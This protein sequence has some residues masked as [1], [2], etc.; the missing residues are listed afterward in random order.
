MQGRALSNHETVTLDRARGRHSWGPPTE[1]F[2]AGQF[3]NMHQSSAING[4]R[5]LLLGSHL[6]EVARCTRMLRLPRP[7]LQALPPGGST[8]KRSGKATSPEGLPQTLTWGHATALA[9]RGPSAFPSQHCRTGQQNPV[10]KG[11]SAL[12][13]H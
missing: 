11:G 4:S 10:Q 3:G 8:S 5:I 9:F 13:L 1:Q 12:P 2:S 6:K 7:P